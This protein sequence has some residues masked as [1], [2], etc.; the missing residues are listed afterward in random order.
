M[1]GAC[2][3]RL[4]YCPNSEHMDVSILLLANLGTGF[5]MHRAMEKQSFG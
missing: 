1:F 3:S 5:S 4:V 2:F